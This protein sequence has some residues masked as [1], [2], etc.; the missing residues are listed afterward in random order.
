[1]S[2]KA[3]IRTVALLSKTRTRACHPPRA[4]PDESMSQSMSDGS[5]RYHPVSCL[6]PPSV[7]PATA[8]GTASIAARTCPSRLP[9]LRASVQV[10]DRRDLDFVA[11]VD[12]AGGIFTDPGFSRIVHF[13]LTAAGAAPLR[14]TSRFVHRDRR[15]NPVETG[16]LRHRAVRANTDASGSGL[17]VRR[18]QSTYVQLARSHLRDVG[19][20]RIRFSGPFEWG[21]T[22]L[23]ANRPKRFS[24]IRPG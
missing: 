5:V 22:L 21:H 19:V 2:R 9:Q 23:S 6:K 12:L 10:D 16:A 20:Q 18:Q 14:G 15:S 4:K 8:H 24:E 17:R 13:G 1:M 7:G 11:V 3:A